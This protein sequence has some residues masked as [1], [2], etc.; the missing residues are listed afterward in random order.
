M[1]CSKGV[2]A[3]VSA[4]LGV[5]LAPSKYVQS[6]DITSHSSEGRVRSDGAIKREGVLKKSL[7]EVS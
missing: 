3:W 2:G 5:G 7:M 4:V 6:V 1:E